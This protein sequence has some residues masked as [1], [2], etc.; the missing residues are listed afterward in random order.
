MRRS[1][2]TL[3]VICSLTL[4][5]GNLCN[6]QS[7]DKQKAAKSK[8]AIQVRIEANSESDSPKPIQI[9]VKVHKR[10]QQTGSGKAK[11][12]SV[13]TSGKIVIVGADG[14]RREF[15]IGPSGGQ[16]DSIPSQISQALKQAGVHIQLEGLP[17]GAQTGK[18]RVIVV[19]P[20]GVSGK[21]A[22]SPGA[23]TTVFERIIQR[24]PTAD[25][26]AIGV[27][28]E[29]PTAALRAQLGLKPKQGMVVRRVLPDMPAATAGLQAFDIILQANQKP[30]SGV[31]QLQRAIQQAGGKGSVKLKILRRGQPLSLD[32]R[33][34]A[35]R[36]AQ[37]KKRNKASENTTKKVDVGVIRIETD[38]LLYGQQLQKLA[39]ELE[40]IIGGSNTI[41]LQAHRLGKGAQRVI[42]VA[43]GK[44]AV[45]PGL[46]QQLLQLQ[47]QIEQLQKQVRQL[48]SRTKPGK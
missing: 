41:R 8:G 20:S 39:P 9:Q 4:A 45:R 6:G 26:P 7:P 47:K 43:D 40:R 44:D 14:K 5:V 10:S 15:T 25:G 3:I 23:S 12:S 29:N 35:P 2:N 16:A 1:I 19:D 37:D 42:V 13:S 30:V 18:H 22:R 48:Q 46:E 38:D 28:L 32:V 17:T 34:A 27:E 36:A 21:G 11:Q 24:S 31:E 33:P